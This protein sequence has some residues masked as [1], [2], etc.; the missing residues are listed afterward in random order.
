MK[1]ILTEDN[2]NLITAKQAIDQYI[3]FI[4]HQEKK[5]LMGSDNPEEVRLLTNMK[6]IK[7]K[8]VQK[9]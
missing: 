1:N 9:K 4:E 2:F 3:E 8:A 6:F 5:P 7:N